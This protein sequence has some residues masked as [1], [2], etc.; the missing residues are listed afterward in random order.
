ML[1]TL[2]KRNKTMTSTLA[3]E[4]LYDKRESEGGLD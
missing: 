3:K 4:T 2:G 1:S